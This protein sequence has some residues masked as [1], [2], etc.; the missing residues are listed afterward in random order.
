MET[1]KRKHEELAEPTDTDR[2][3][4]ALC[5]LQILGGWPFV[6]ILLLLIPETKDRPF[7]RYN[8]ILALLTVVALI[9]VTVVTCGLGALG[10]L[11]FFYWAYQ[12]YRGEW[13][14]IPLLS[15]WVPL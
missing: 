4:G 7:I 12:A 13:V 9:P 6:S 2:L 14:R 15:D 8:A 11:L 1:P 5:W 10:F 3:F